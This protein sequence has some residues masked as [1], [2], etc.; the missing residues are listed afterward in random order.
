MY[1]TADRM[2]YCWES[3]DMNQ[4]VDLQTMQ[5]TI[6]RDFI[7]PQITFFPSRSQIVF[8]IRF[9]FTTNPVGWHQEAQRKQLL[10]HNIYQCSV[11]L[12]RDRERGNGCN[13]IIIRARVA[14][15]EITTYINNCECSE[16]YAIYQDTE[17][18]RSC[19]LVRYYSRM[20]NTP[21]RPDHMRFDQSP[22]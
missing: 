5:P 11:N 1:T 22:H 10:R 15:L 6:V 3:E 7:S 16:L 8:G 2:I 19:I 9:D 20:C 17:P 13:C 21:H 18:G 12:V 14:I 4:C